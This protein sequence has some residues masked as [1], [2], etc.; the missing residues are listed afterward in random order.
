MDKNLLRLWQ[1]VSSGSSKKEHL[2]E[3]LGLSL[4]QTTRYI[5]KWTKEGWLTFTSGRG[6]G[7]VS[8]LQWLKNVEEIYEDHIMK[9]MDQEPIEITSKYLLFDWSIES[10]QRLLKKF[11]SKFG[12]TQSTNVYDKLIVP[13]KYPF[14][15]IHPLESA[16]IQSA[17]IVANVYNKL[18][19]IDEKGVVLPELA[20]SW[21]L[22]SYKLRLYLKKDIKFHDGSVLSA[23]DVVFCLQRL[24]NHEDFRGLWKHA[25]NISALSPLI[26]D[27]DFSSGWSCSLQMLSKL[28]A[29]IYKEVNGRLFGT[30]CFYIEENNEF[31]TTLLAFKDYF[32]ERPLLDA[33]EFVQVPLDFDMIY[34]SANQ[35]KED[36]TFQVESNSGFGVIIMN[37]FRQSAIQHKGVRD[38]LHY[39]I[40]KQRHEIDKVSTRLIANHEG[41]LIGQSQLYMLKEVERPHFTEPIIIRGVNYT[42]QTT[43]WLKETLEKENIPVEIKWLSFED[44]IKRKGN[45]HFDLFIHGEGFE[46]NHDFSFYYFL[47]NGRSPLANVL[48]T[49]PTLL[50][51]LNNYVN[52]PFKKWNSL[53]LQM[54]KTLISSSIMIPLYYSKRQIPFS[55]DL[56]NI[57]ITHFGYVD[58]SKLWVKPNLTKK[59]H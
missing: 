49:D 27:I 41:C 28:N 34:R 31:K 5:H 52:T 58:F 37:T 4:K 1:S 21:D 11:H 18:V 23:E 10:K 25:D 2:A 6:R 26:V 35:E 33:V 38:Y 12:Y 48:E 24:R 16:D 7:N 9:M 46:I 39:I 44:T 14:L 13:R 40:G 29:C 30:G 45:E 55:H 47:Q 54:E 22:T 59:A 42:E 53:N 3:V 17:N 50:A 20:H 51:L 56:M 43:M 32:Q 57:N 8:K 36:S 19:S 15:T